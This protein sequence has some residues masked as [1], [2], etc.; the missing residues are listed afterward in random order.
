MRKPYIFLLVSIFTF[1][2]LI[3]SSYYD[4]Y[5]SCDD[6]K[7]RLYFFLQSEGNVGLTLLSATFFTLFI[8]TG[9]FNKVESIIGAI[10]VWCLALGFLY[11][12]LGFSISRSCPDYRK[13]ADLQSV[14][15][16][17]ALYKNEHNAYPNSLEEMKNQYAD[18]VMNFN[19]YY[20]L[21]ENTYRLGIIL[22]C[23]RN[24]QG[25]LK[26]GDPSY[27]VGP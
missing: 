12:S 16:A 13:I 27:E 3:I 18:Y 20:R 23:P 2:V 6:F 14:K 9:K 8:L 5:C 21:Q 24:Y 1:I 25:D 26:P 10:I 19:G 11:I 17:L 7:H 15:T 22:E 4:A